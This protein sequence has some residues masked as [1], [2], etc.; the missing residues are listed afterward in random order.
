MPSIS[1]QEQQTAILI[2]R[3]DNIGDLL[4]TTPL[5]SELRKR[6]PAARIDALVNSY[7]SPVLD[8]NPDLD[9]VYFYT[10]AKHRAAGETVPGV[11][12]R[13][14]MLMLSMRQA[15]YNQVYLASDGNIERQMKLARWLGAASVIGFKPASGEPPAGL[16]IQI[17]RKESGHE[18]ER[19]WALLAESAGAETPGPMTLRPS[20]GQA[21]AI[22]QRLAAMPWYNPE[23]PVL[24]IHISARKIPQR[25]PVPSFVALM[26]GL[27]QRFEAQFVLFWS[28]GDEDNPLH[29]GDDRKAAAIL[30]AAAGLPV[31]PYPTAQL[32]EL[33]GGL[34]AC[35]TMICS[36][37]GAM[38]MGAALG[39]SIISF[40]GNSD[41]GRWFPWGV[42]HELLQKPSRNVTD[43][44]VEEALAAYQRLQ[45]RIT[46]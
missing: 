14:L 29:P 4:C 24:A 25:W 27:H 23:K 38:H 5:I 34:S 42:P 6:H 9:H 15:K 18:V 22:R 3:R 11:Y 7:N 2:I 19:C 12:W 36:D 40:F 31:L 28:P 8:E 41:V 30:E 10:K 44:S 35:Q 43:I 13:R 32:A 33:T 26:Q 37:G 45:A 16:S 1:P 39:L 17:T 46:R 21:Q 20:A